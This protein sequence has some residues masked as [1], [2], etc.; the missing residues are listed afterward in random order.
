MATKKKNDETKQ[1]KSDIRFI[2]KEMTKMRIVCAE[3]MGTSSACEDKVRAMEV[4]V[5]EMSTKLRKLIADPIYSVPDRLKKEVEVLT[6]KFVATNVRVNTMDQKLKEKTP[7]NVIKRFDLIEGRVDDLE[8]QVHALETE[9]FDS[10]PSA[11]VKDDSLTE[12]SKCARCGEAFVNHTGKNENCPP[13]QGGVEHGSVFLHQQVTL[14]EVIEKSKAD[15]P[16]VDELGARLGEGGFIP[17]S[18]RAG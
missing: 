18:P 1:L 11:V 12:E 4:S 16:V 2:G 13:V 10:K 9:L 3:A 6:E 7:R 15:E 5:K 14:D 17:R 8:S